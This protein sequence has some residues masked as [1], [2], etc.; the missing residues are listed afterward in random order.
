MRVL[1][2]HTHSNVWSEQPR[3]KVDPS[4]WDCYSEQQ[5]EN[6]PEGSWY[7]G[8]AGGE[9]GGAAGLA[10]S[11]LTPS[12]APASSPAG[13]QQWLLFKPKYCYSF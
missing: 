2:P 10:S 3:Y 1:A 11:S 9:D 5:T 12:K 13:A 4:Y 6:N 7:L 8:V